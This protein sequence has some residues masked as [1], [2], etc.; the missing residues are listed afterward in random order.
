M[1]SASSTTADQQAVDAPAMS[2]KEL[3]I[4]SYISIATFIYDYLLDKFRLFGEFPYRLEL[5]LRSPSG[6]LGPPNK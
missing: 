2:N 4:K 5:I 1:P 3:N 6:E